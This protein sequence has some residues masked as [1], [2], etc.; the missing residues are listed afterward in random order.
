MPRLPTVAI[1]GR[2]NTGKSTLF[3]RIVG[4]RQAIISETAGTTRDHVAAKIEG[5][6]LDYLLIDTGGMGGGTQDTEMEDDVHA[7]SVLAVEAADLIIFTINSREELTASDFK[8]ADILRRRARSHIPVIIAPTKCDNPETIHN[9]LPQYYEL[10]IAEEI[11]PISAVHDIGIETL[12]ETTETHLKEL[13]F[14]KETTEAEETAS[15]I[16]RI[17]IIGKPNV[18]KSSIVNALM[19]DPDREKSPRLV[20]PVAGTTRDA[21]DTI[22]RSQDKEYIFVDTAGLRRHADKEEDI[23]N[24]AILRTIQALAHSDIVILVLDSTE[25]PSRQDKRIANMAVEEGKGLIIFVNK[26]DLLKT[27]EKALRMQEI[28]HELQFCRFAPLIQGSA[29]TRDGLL[30][31]FETIDM[32]ER[33]RNRRIPTKELHTW[34]RQSLQQQP[35]GE[36][37]RCKHITQADESAPTFVLFVSDP[38]KVQLSQL[39]FL[40]KRMRSTFG[41]EGTPIRWITK[42]RSE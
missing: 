42:G 20:S 32:V 8:I 10:G 27:E 35:M 1:I 9:I 2:P 41:F 26:I 11:I 22:I 5:E 21:T 24:F 29:L 37:Q 14:G 34:L 30:K 4:R 33:N 39:R 23:E 36:L 40:E 6:Q 17:A 3:N 15:A 19:S 28:Q 7:Q 18:G 16:S 13:H 31:I 25:P 38:K 12:K